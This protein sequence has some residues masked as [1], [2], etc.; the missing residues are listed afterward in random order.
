LRSRALGSRVVVWVSSAWGT[1]SSGGRSYTSYYGTAVGCTTGAQTQLGALKLVGIQ[2]LLQS[3]M[4][5][6][7]AIWLSAFDCRPSY[8]DI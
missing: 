6:T 8:I 3:A 1:S 4:R 7:T 2:G 5:M